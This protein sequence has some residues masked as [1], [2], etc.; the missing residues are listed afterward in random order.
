MIAPA[1]DDA[2]RAR[3]LLTSALALDF[4]FDPLQAARARET[5]PGLRP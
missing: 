2:D 1:V 3:A 5:L 4:A